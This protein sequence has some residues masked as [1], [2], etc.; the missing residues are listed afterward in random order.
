MQSTKQ[1]I[2]SLG[3][4]EYGFDIMDVNIIEKAIPIEPVANF[5]QNLK[6]IIRLRGDVIP[7]Y[8]LRRKF[9][10]EDVQADDDTRFIIT[11]SKDLQVGYEVD[12]MKEIVQLEEEQLNEAP[13]I[14]KNKDTTYIKFI[15]KWNDKLV[16]IMNHDGIMTEEEINQAK[17]VVKKLSEQQNEQQNGLQNE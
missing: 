7:V 4:H 3:E 9:G 13:S 5:P 14:V 15:T 2:F 10:L 6:G 8:S 16:I 11:T 12:G 17:E 1:V